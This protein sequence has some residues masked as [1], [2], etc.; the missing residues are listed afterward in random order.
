MAH[1]NAS[2]GKTIKSVPDLVAQTDKVSSTFNKGEHKGLNAKNGM[3]HSRFGVQGK[4]HI[5]ESINSDITECKDQTLCGCRKQQNQRVCQFADSEPGEDSDNG[6]T[7]PNGDG[8]DV[9]IPGTT[10]ECP[11]CN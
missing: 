5:Y 11:L 10:C 8:E 6:I 7:L 3:E 1:A 2:A 9:V 4:V